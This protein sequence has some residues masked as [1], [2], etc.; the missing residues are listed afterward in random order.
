[1]SSYGLSRFDFIYRSLLLTKFF[2]KGWGKPDDLKRI[3]SLRRRLAN[4]ATAGSLLSQ[5]RLAEDYPVVLTKEEK[6][7][8]H[9]ILEGHFITPVVKHLPGLLPKES[10]KAH[11]QAVLP[12][13]WPRGSSNRFQPVVIQ[14]AGTGD[15]YYWRRRHLMALPMIREKG[16]G[17]IILECPFYGL[18]KPKEQF[19]SS[20]QNVSDLFLMGACLIFESAILYNWCDSHGYGPL[21]SHGIS[22]GGHMASLGATVWPKPIALVPC[23]SWT[24]ASLTFTRGALGGA[25]DWDLLRRQ[26]AKS[27]AFKDDIANLVRCE[28]NAFQAG[29]EF[30]QNLDNIAEEDQDKC[31]LFE[32]SLDNYRSDTSKRRINATS[33]NNITDYNRDN[34]KKALFEDLISSTLTSMRKMDYSVD[35]SKIIGREWSRNSAS[36]KNAVTRDVLQREAVQFMRGIMDECTH[37]KNYDTPVDPELIIIVAAELDAYMPRDGITALPDIWPGAKIRYIR[38]SGHIA[39][40]LFKQNVFR[41]AIYDAIDLHVNKYPQGSYGQR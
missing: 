40:Y 18:R 15:H 13:E 31:R 37:L 32:H 19:R 28:D 9:I 25:L 30:A 12:V 41:S 11:F 17:S 14:Y 3:F 10:E 29:K 33:S 6:R 36:L 5:T 39:S 1:M 22:M 16:I 4:R 7:N 23:L 20:L 8:D 34:E 2:T 26:Y 24:S 21:V 27:Q 38:N 35:W